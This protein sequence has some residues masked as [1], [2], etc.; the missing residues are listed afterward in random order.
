[1]FSLITT[2]ITYK[3]KDKGERTL[4]AVFSRYTAILTGETLPNGTRADAVYLILN[5]IY[6]TT[7]SPK[8]EGFSGH[9]SVERLRPDGSVRAGEYSKRHSRRGRRR[10]RR[11]TKANDPT[12]F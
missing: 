6:V 1:M 8:G 3:T 5:D 2:K 9:R 12:T 7:P 4:E 11:N 10:S